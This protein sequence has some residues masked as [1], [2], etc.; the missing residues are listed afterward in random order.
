MSDDSDI[1][2]VEYEPVSAPGP[3]MPGETKKAEL[4]RLHEE[5]APSMVY[6]PRVAATGVDSFEVRA[7]AENTELIPWGFWGGLLVLAVSLMIIVSVKGLYSMWDVFWAIF[8]LTFGVLLWRYGRRTTLEEKTI[9]HVDTARELVDWP[10]SVA[11]EGAISLDF[12]Q[13]TEVVFGMTSYP[14]SDRRRDVKVHAFTLLL[15][16]RRERLLPVI[17]ATPNKEEAHEVGKL[18]AGELGMEITYV[19][20]GIK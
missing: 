1:I 9:L 7:D 10:T 16:D 13:I 11:G 6:Q 2:D 15:R 8:A 14:V 4:E 18:L 19:G 20:K 17:E 5:N 3:R 12:D